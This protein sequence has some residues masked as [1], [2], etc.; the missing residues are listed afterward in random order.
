PPGRLARM[1]RADEEPEEPDTPEP[2]P[3]SPSAV[4]PKA[5]VVTAAPSQGV[6]FEYRTEVLTAEQVLDGTTLPEKLAQESSEGWDLVD[7]VQAQ[8][9]HVILLRKPKKTDRGERRVGFF[10]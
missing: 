2:E 9:K 6:A 4:S 8:D 3:Q 7:L 10:R 1:L 5:L